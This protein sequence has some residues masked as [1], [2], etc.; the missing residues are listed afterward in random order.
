MH[1]LMFYLRIKH[2]VS[3]GEV[4]LYPEEGLFIDS[5]RNVS[6]VPDVRLHPWMLH[7]DSQQCFCVLSGYQF[8][9]NIVMEYVVL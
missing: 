9:L 3:F 8:Q 5:K 1:L 6:I 2:T 4:R 7:L